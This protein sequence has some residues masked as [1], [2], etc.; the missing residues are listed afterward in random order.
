MQVESD[1]RRWMLPAMLMGLIMTAGCQAPHTP[2]ATVQWIQVTQHT[3]E[4]A[5]LEVGLTVSNPNDVPLPVRSV[6]YT[7]RVEDVGRFRFEDHPPVTL[8]PMDERTIVLAG[9]FVNGWRVQPGQSIRATGQ[10]RYQRPGQ[11]P[12]LLAEYGFPYPS[13]GFEGRSEVA[14][15]D[16]TQATVG[17]R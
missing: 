9:A 8:A 1:M 2:V 17:L 13:A 16:E 14:L 4:G 10:V 12:R 6:S 5:R 15:P 11:W 7:I 3:E